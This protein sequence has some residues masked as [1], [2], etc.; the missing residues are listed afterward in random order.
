MIGIQSEEKR[1]QDFE[2]GHAGSYVFVGIV[3]VLI[4]IFSLIAIVDS[5]LES[6]GQK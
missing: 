3:M 6:A 4:F 1:K 2:G 5:I